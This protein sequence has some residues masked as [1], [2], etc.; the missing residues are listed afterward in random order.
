[1]KQYDVVIVGAGPAGLKCAEILAQARKKIIVL[2]KNKVIGDKVCAGGL[3]FKNFEF[4]IP[5]KLFQR[6]FNKV[7]VLTILGKEEIKTEN[8]IIFATIDRKDLGKWM[9]EKAKRAG[10]EIKT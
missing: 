2:E 3:D 4:G 7:K 9:A 6:K 10:A 8:K 5:E 1:M